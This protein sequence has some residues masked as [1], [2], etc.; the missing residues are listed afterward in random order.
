[1]EAS[2]APAENKMGV[3][4][5]NKLILTMSLPMMASML[6]QALYNIVDSV[7]VAQISENA[8][9]AVSLAF[10]MQSLMIAVATGTGVGVNALL[11]KRLG[12]KDYE[13]VNRV[14]NNGIY[15]AVF[16]YII[17]L[18]LGIFAAR[19]FMMV[20]N[21]TTEIVEHGV[22]YLTI[23]MTLSFGVFGQVI[24]ERLVQSTG[25]TMIAMI[26][27]G[28]GAVINLIFDPIMIFGYFGFPAMGVAGAAL[29]TVLGQIIA[30]ILGVI[31]NFKYNHEIK[32]NPAR[33]RLDLK[34]VGRIYAI[35]VPSIIMQSIGSVMVIGMNK[36]LYTFS[37]S[38]QAV[39]GIYFKLQSF[40]FMPVFGLNNGVVPIIAY[41]FGAG[42]Q[43][44][45]KKTIRVAAV[46]AVAIMLIGIMIMEIIP[47]KLLLLFDA[48]ENL[49]NIGVP[50]LRIICLSFI[51][52]GFCITIGSVFQALGN[53]VYS[54]I[55][56]AA[57]Q[58]CVLLPVAYLMSLTGNL[59]MVW[60]S[61]P[62]AEL[63]SVAM[64]LFFYRRIHSRVIRF[65]GVETNDD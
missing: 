39:F 21:D 62:I 33:Y 24:M 53:G 45:M 56:S 20:Q 47:D 7:F 60:L 55:V 37:S 61:F 29:A 27:Q 42:R 22:T 58:L 46:Y 50:A 38:A 25:K 44:R 6:V 4:P 16:S 54:M 13:G 23:V 57:R 51:F 10:P 52:A 17:F 59:D 35:G 31:L 9:T 3:M 30:A 2:S 1:M 40:F 26:T 8:L 14:A 41:N 34:T 43:D 49:I 63:M 28:L 15:L 65:V 32:I 11:S 5:I 18:L 36:I 12:M 48:S 64:T 19:P